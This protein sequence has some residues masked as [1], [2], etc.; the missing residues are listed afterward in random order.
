MLGDAILIASV[1]ILGAGWAQA[2]LS[3]AAH[4]EAWEVL[5]GR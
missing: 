4:P 5:E 3:H 2:K 1:L